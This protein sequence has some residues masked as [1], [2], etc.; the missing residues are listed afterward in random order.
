MKTNEFKNYINIF[1]PLLNGEFGDTEPHEYLLI[2]DH[3]I[4]D[5]EFKDIIF[6]ACENRKVFK[7]RIMCR[8]Q[9]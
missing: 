7:W 8:Y 4:A 6:Q 9:C 3:Q 5:E 1:E 2:S